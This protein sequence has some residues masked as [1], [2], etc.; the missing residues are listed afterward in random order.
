[1]DDEEPGHLINPQI[2]ELSTDEQDGEEGCL[3]FPGCSSRPSAPGE[4]R[5]RGFNVH[6]TR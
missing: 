3:S 6:A 5:A 2:V 4:V 1:V